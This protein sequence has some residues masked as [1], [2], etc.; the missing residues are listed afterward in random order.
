MLGQAFFPSIT[1]RLPNNKTLQIENSA[2]SPEAKSVAFNGK[3]IHAPSIS[4]AALME[5]G[6]LAF[7]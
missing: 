7:R 4:H 5:G 6:H 1:V 2:S 3:P